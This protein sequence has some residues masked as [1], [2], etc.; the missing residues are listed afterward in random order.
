MKS[1]YVALLFSLALAACGGSDDDRTDAGISPDG[2]VTDIDAGADP[3]DIGAIP[4]A[5]HA[6]EEADFVDLSGGPPEGRMIMVPRGTFMF[7]NPCITI[8]AGQSVMF[9]W[10]FAMHPLT[11]GV[12]PD[13]TGTGTEPSSIVA[14]STGTLSDQ[15]F[16]ATGNYP[17]YCAVHFAGS[18]VGV[19]RVIP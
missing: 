14:Q 16:P 9:M 10:D 1:R 3:A 15:V 6:C 12:A 18:M 4:G 7:D 11:P 17:F 5:L 2:G 8:R 13:H 19:V